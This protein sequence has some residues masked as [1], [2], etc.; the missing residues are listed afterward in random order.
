MKGFAIDP[1]RAAKARMAAQIEEKPLTQVEAARLLDVHPITL[2]RV[3][4]GKSPGSAEL[5]E[6]MVELYGV[7]REY[8]LGEPERADEFDLAR[9]RMATGVAKIVSGFEEMGM[10]FDLL[11]EARRAADLAVDGAEVEA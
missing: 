8:L 10:A 6:R 4:N 5:L 2:N 1:V 7:S 3:E 11:N 9:E